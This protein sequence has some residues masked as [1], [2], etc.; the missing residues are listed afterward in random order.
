MSTPLTADVDSAFMAEINST[1]HGLSTLS[2][3][4][5]RI[6]AQLSQW[7]SL[8]SYQRD[9]TLPLVRQSVTEFAH[10]RFLLSL[11]AQLFT[12]MSALR[13]VERDSASTAGVRPPS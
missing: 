6:Q 11:V 12:L 7:K 4:A 9:L 13:V 1:I 2:T 10:Y 5:L 8:P 3:V